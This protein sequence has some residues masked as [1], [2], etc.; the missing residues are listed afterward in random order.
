MKSSI[1]NRLE[2]VRDRFEEVSGLFCAVMDHIS[3]EAEG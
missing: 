2:S 3:D 1:K